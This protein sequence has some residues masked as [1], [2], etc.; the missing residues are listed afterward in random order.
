MHFRSIYLTSYSRGKKM[1]RRFE[2]VEEE[3]SISDIEM[4]RRSGM[5]GR[6]A[7]PNE[8]ARTRLFAA[9]IAALA[10]RNGE[11]AE[12]ADEEDLTEVELP[13][14]SKK[15][16]RASGRNAHTKSPKANVHSFS[17]DAMDTSPVPDLGAF[18]SIDSVIGSSNEV[19]IPCE[20]DRGRSVD[21]NNKPLERAKGA[22]RTRSNSPFVVWGRVKSSEAT[23]PIA[24]KLS[25]E[26]TKSAGVSTR[27]VVSNAKR[28]GSP[29]LRAGKRVRSDGSP[30]ASLH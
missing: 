13:S 18:S 23:A 10:A 21:I 6:I 14:P 26:A 16:N 28:E 24:D 20:P 29:L 2:D 22:R 12:E 15:P 19:E 1:I 17:S 11:A 27:R 3:D 5:R 9:E 25:S 4:Q 30:S 8:K 7:R